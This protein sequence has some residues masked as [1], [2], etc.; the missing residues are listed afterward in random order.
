MAKAFTESEIEQVVE[1]ARRLLELG[2]VNVQDI[3]PR[4]VKDDEGEDEYAITLS[5]TGGTIPLRRGNTLV[6]FESGVIYFEGGV[7]PTLEVTPL[8]SISRPYF[9][10]AVIWCDQTVNLI[11]EYKGL[12]KGPYRMTAMGFNE[13]R[14]T[15][16]TKMIFQ[17][18]T[19]M[20]AV[21]H[22]VV[23]TLPQPP[24]TPISVWLYIQRYGIITTSLAT[25][26]DPATSTSAA[27]FTEFRTL[28]SRTISPVGQGR[29][30]LH[31]SHISHSSFIIENTG[32]EQ[33]LVRLATQYVEGEAYEFLPETGGA[34]GLL[35]EANSTL[36]LEVS[37][38]SHRM[39]FQ[40]IFA[41]GGAATT[42]EVQFW[43][44]K[45]P[46]EEKQLNAIRWITDTTTALAGAGTFTGTRRDATHALGGIAVR[47][48]ADVAGTLNFQDSIDGTTW[49]TVQA[50][51]IVAN[52]L[53][54]RV[55]SPGAKYYRLTY[56]NGAGLQ[57]T[58]ELSHAQLPAGA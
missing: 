14:N 28:V 41:P 13:V 55:Y 40:A 20:P 29:N 17:E 45:E 48:F 34:A 56:T 2:L 24:I 35:V 8:S 3:A 25:F 47:C 22:V 26:T 42:L 31:V 32:S 10:S 16:F 15:R 7:N 9:Q 49:R 43:G 38:K 5:R 4:A 54:E 53:E 6:D 33:A 11:L 39:F 58:F 18:S 27:D 44:T 37:K 23:G 21:V 19:G 52:T 51:A 36:T 1:A 46:V 57:A 12:R 30:N 50:V